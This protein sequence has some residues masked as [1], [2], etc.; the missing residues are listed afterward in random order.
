MRIL[1]INPN[2]SQSM[3]DEIRSTLEQYKVEGDELTV[4]SSV[5]GSESLES[6]FDYSLASV[7]VMETLSNY[8][9]YEY[10]G[11]LLACFG[12]PGLYAL[13]EILLS[14]VIGIAEASLSTSILLAETYSIITA[15]QKA[16]PMMKNMVRQYGMESRMTSIE[17]MNLSVLDVDCN[18]QMLKEKF[19]EVIDKC[20]SQGAESI[21]LGCAGMTGISSE[22]QEE[23]KIP[24]IDPIVVGYYNLRTLIMSKLFI[25]NIGMYKEPYPQNITGYEDIV[26]RGG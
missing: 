18:K 8:N 24:V 2:T 4:I 23:K 5:K 20:I 10:D 25:S 6:F 3:T 9:T 11:I 1:V 19:G 7:A 16:I 12:D 14:P 22:L 26:K 21:I 17:S 15:S 13:K